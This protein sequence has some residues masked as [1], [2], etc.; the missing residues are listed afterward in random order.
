VWKPKPKSSNALRV[1]DSVLF[2]IQQGIL[3]I[4]GSI[5]RE[6]VWPFA[7]M[8]VLR[9]FPLWARTARG[10]CHGAGGNFTMKLPRLPDSALGSV[11]PDLGAPAHGDMKL[12]YAK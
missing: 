6:L 8:L 9:V 11:I 7:A 10:V 4:K 3:A 1:A 2:H 5:V 12:F